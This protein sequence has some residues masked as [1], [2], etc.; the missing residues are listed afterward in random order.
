MRSVFNVDDVMRNYPFPDPNSQIQAEPVEVFYNLPEY[1]YVVNKEDLKVAV[2]NEKDKAW[3]TE[4]IEDSFEFEINSKKLSFHTK[5][6]AQM[7]LLL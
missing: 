6:F 3:S 2:W 1:V 5:K 7:A 4:P